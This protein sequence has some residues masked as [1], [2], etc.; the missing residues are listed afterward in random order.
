MLP[1][2]WGFTLLPS[3]FFTFLKDFSTTSII[4]IVPQN[5]VLVEIPPSSTYYEAVFIVL[6]QEVRILTFVMGMIITMESKK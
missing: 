5:P 6:G 4:R 3:S 2:N 1:R